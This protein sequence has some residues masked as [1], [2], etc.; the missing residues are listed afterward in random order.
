MAAP[1]KVTANTGKNGE[2]RKLL[3]GNGEKTVIEIESTINSPLICVAAII[4]GESIPKHFL[5]CKRVE[6]ALR[7]RCKLIS[8]HQQNGL[9]NVVPCIYWVLRLT[10]LLLLLFDCASDSSWPPQ[11]FFYRRRSITHFLSAV[12]LSTLVLYIQNVK[13]F[14]SWAP[15][16]TLCIEI[17]FRN[18]S[19]WIKCTFCK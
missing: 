8:K 14:Y 7:L 10:V 4:H 18:V 5:S 9:P 15:T 1:Q 17:T 12:S 19:K 3:S 11:L 2:F 16:K 13:C 6:L